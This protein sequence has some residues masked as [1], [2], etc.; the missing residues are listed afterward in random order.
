MSAGAFI[1]SR[2]ETSSAALGGIIMPI[3][4]QPETE[5]LVIGGVTNTPPAGAV[6]FPLRVS[7]SA[8]D[9]EYGV[10]PR[11]VTLRF[12]DPADVPTGY[13]GQDV[14]VPLLTPAAEAAAI[15][16]AVGTYLT[17]AVK[18]ISTKPEDFR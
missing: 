7:V 10:K 13:S 14:I 6:D 18:V 9:G 17:K 5:A 16:E 1:L 12:T 2:Y 3:K 11:K 15:P 8:T 4:I